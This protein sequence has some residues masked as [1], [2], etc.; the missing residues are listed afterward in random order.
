MKIKKILFLSLFLII[1]LLSFIPNTVNADSIEISEV[2]IDFDGAVPVI[3]EAPK[4]IIINSD[5]YEIVDQG[6][7]E[8]ENGQATNNKVTTFEYGKAYFFEMHIKAKV[9]YE[10]VSP[11]ITTKN[12]VLDNDHG[13]GIIT[14]Q[15]NPYYGCVFIQGTYT[16]GTVHA[17]IELDRASNIIPI[18]GETP[19]YLTI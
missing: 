10:F 3:G 5:K 16:T 6:W 13:K 19:K 8:K 18:V 7:H 9:D 1:G 17:N 11:V 4:D 14:N 2:T 15:N 12:I